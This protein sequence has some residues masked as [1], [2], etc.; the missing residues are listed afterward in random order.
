MSNKL[1]SAMFTS[2]QFCLSQPKTN[3]IFR[4]F[5]VNEFFGPKDKVSCIEKLVI[6]SGIQFLFLFVLTDAILLNLNLQKRTPDLDF[7]ATVYTFAGYQ[8]TKYPN[9]GNLFFG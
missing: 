3:R 5:R 1:Q 8:R 7:F 6:R 9:I 2:F 4:T